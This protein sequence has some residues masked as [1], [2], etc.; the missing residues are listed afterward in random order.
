MKI[1]D[2]KTFVPTVAAVTTMLLLLQLPAIAP[3]IGIAPLMPLHAAFAIADGSSCI[4]YDRSD[5]MIEL[6][7]DTTFEQLARN[8]GDDSA[9]KNLG[10]GEYLLSASIKVTEKSRL[11]IALPAVAWI[12]ISNEGSPQYNINV[13]G[14]RMDI[15]GVKITSWDPAKNSTVDQNKRGSVPRPYIHEQDARGGVIQ[16]SE[17]GYLGYEGGH[18]RGLSFVDKSTDVEIRNSVFHH[19]WYAFYSNG[20]S[21]FTL[22]GNTYHDNHLYAID[23]HTGTHDMN[24]TNNHVYNNPGSGI[25]CSIDCSNI[26]IENN[27]IHDN[28]KN[29]INL[30]R[31]MHDSIV[32]NNTIWDSPRGIVIHDSKGNEVYGNTI[33]NVSEGIHYTDVQVTKNKV[34]NNTISEKQVA[35]TKQLG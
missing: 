13:E 21:N 20:A 22:D 18:L 31:N 25:I 7:C 1:K 34:Y 5:R 14:G 11:T 29:G 23:P 2:H 10:N 32:R 6:A 19:F 3:I 33:H 17:L 35:D 16:N 28:G 26:L 9:I 15:N 12:K 8:I 24:I 27:M 4:N 30:S